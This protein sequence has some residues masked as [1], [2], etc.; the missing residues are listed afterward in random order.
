V[1]LHIDFCV[2]DLPASFISGVE[3]SPKWLHVLSLATDR[4]DEQL[5]EDLAPIERRAATNTDVDSARDTLA[6]SV[7]TVTQHVEEL[8]DDVRQVSCF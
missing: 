4:E 7:A 3:G 5:L 1:N 2:Q 6:A 8:Q